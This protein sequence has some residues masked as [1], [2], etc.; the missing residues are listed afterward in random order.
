MT[1]VMYV[2]PSGEFFLSIV[3]ISSILIGVATISPTGDRVNGRKRDFERAITAGVTA[4][5]FVGL[6]NGYLSHVNKGV[7]D[8][9]VKL[10]NEIVGG[11][12]F[13]GH[14]FVTDTIIEEFR[15]YK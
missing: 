14:N 2:D 4:G 10:I 3:L 6:A 7:N 15:R 11:I 12:I 13:S 5:I 1:S 9:S 8:I